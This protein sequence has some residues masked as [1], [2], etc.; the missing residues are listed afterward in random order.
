MLSTWPRVGILATDP[1]Q[2]SVDKGQPM[3]PRGPRGTPCAP[4]LWE[5]GLR[6]IGSH[7]AGFCTEGLDEQ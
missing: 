5:R 4:G 3:K 6:E 1:T 7:K 2:W